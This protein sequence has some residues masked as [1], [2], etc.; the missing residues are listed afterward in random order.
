MV[1]VWWSV[2]WLCSDGS[3]W[4]QCMVAA[5]WQCSGGT[6]QWEFG[7]GHFY[8]GASCLFRWRFAVLLNRTGWVPLTTTPTT[9]GIH[10]F[11]ATLCATLQCM[12]PCYC[13]RLNLLQRSQTALPAFKLLKLVGQSANSLA[14]LWNESGP[15]RQYR[16]DCSSLRYWV[17]TIDYPSIPYWVNGIGYSTVRYWVNAIDCFTSVPVHRPALGNFKQ[18]TQLLGKFFKLL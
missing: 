17:N 9:G 3:V 1:P 11:C 7:R 4:W 15:N 12:P 8:T 5:C 14:T 16:I 18:I 13:L 2:W 6:Q 10:R